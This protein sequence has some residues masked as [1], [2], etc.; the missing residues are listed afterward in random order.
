MV[1]GNVSGI[2]PGP[3]FS[4]SLYLRLKFTF[5]G[6]VRCVIDK[7]S[8][9]NA[10]RKFAFFCK[11]FVSLLKVIIINKSNKILIFLVNYNTLLLK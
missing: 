11:K 6:N 2:E 4:S 7:F 5:W 10:K 9:K 8:G 3:S 1:K